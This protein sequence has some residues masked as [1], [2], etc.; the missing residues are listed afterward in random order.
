MGARMGAR[1]GSSLLS[2]ACAAGGFE[3]A[4][5]NVALCMQCSLAGTEGIRG[6]KKAK[7]HRGRL[8]RERGVLMRVSEAIAALIDETSKNLQIGKKTSLCSRMNC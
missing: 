4:P 2:L 1:S 5:P 8:R 7:D 6:C 3:K